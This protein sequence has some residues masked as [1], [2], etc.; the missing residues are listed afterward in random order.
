MGMVIMWSWNHNKT[1]LCEAAANAWVSTMQIGIGRN[2]TELSSICERGMVPN[3]IRIINT[4][5]YHIILQARTKESRN[6]LIR[7]VAYQ[8]INRSIV[9]RAQ[10]LEDLMQEIAKTVHRQ[11]SIPTSPVYTPTYLPVFISLL[12]FAFKHELYPLTKLYSMRKRQGNN[13]RE[14]LKKTH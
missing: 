11:E 5:N 4:N 3:P 6:L 13:V 2:S 8:I 14:W 10:K 1:Q 7:S 9:I 12:N